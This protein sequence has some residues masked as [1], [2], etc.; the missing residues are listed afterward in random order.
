VN[1][2]QLPR[3]AR[4]RVR[5]AT[6]APDSSNA[7]Q[8]MRPPPP[9]PPLL[10][11]PLLPPPPP[12]DDEP[13]DGTG[14]TVV[15][16]VATLLVA[17]GSVPENVAVAVAV[18]VPAVAEFTTMS[19]VDGENCNGAKSHVT[20]PLAIAQVPPCDGVAPVTVLPVTGR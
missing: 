15:L 2:E 13:E 14:F 7:S 5:I 18:T 3:N 19:T 4:R 20:V 17:T 8:S 12:P 9:P 1:H 16:A 11:P 10:P 6:T